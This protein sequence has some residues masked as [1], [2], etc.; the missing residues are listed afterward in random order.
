MEL[1]QECESF[2][3]RP[4]AKVLMAGCFVVYAT[5]YTMPTLM[6]FMAGH[7]TNSTEVGRQGVLVY[8]DGGSFYKGRRYWM[9][10]VSISMMEITRTD[11]SL[12]I[13]IYT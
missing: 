13:Y 2:D 10:L 8:H 5:T 11:L 3:G 1:P 12:S 4:E 9:R 6:P 7:F